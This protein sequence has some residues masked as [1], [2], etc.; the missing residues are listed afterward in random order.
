VIRTPAALL[1]VTR[2]VGPVASCEG[3]LENFPQRPG[4][5]A[6]LAAHPPAHEPP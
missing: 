3:R 6:Y 4:F 2:L 1:L 5:A